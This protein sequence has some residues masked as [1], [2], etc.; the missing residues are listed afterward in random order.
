MTPEAFASMLRSL[1]YRVEDS[2]VETMHNEVA[3][4]FRAAQEQN[5]MRA[6]NASDTPWPPRKRNYAW[7]ILRKT[8]RMLKAASQR[9]A[10]GNIQ[11]TIGRQLQLGI[12]DSDVP[13]AKYHQFGTSRLPTRQFFYLRER[14]RKQ[15]RPAVREHLLR[16]MSKAK[17][18]YSAR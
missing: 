5:F 17:A 1:P 10:P 16:I 15:L 7:P 12:R 13:Y 3:N 11:R 18:Q 2:G 9:N 14:D 4:V 6:S 8:R